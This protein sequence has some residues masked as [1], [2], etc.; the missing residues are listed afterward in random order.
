MRKALWGNG[1]GP[2]P[3]QYDAQSSILGA[4]I[5]AVGLT[6]GSWSANTARRAA[7]CDP[8]D[9]WPCSTGPFDPSPVTGE[10]VHRAAQP[11]IESSEACS[12]SSSAPSVAKPLAA[13]RTVAMTR[14]LGKGVHRGVAEVVGPAEAE[15]PLREQPD[16]PG[17]DCSSRNRVRRVQPSPAGD[18]GVGDV[19]RSMGPIVP[20]GLR[21]AWRP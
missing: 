16:S 9:R 7:S 8:A 5:C 21:R 10:Q 14:A 3:L 12:T 1:T 2:A 18:G 17:M 15:P 11:G 13:S 6:M 4:R 20:V 19:T